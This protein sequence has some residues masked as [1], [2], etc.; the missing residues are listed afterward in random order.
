MSAQSMQALAGA[1]EVRLAGAA[2]RREL[3]K[4]PRREGLV[5]C[6]EWLETGGNGAEGVRLRKLLTAIHRMGDWGA[7]DLLNTAATHPASQVRYVRELTERQRHTL[8]GVLRRKAA[9]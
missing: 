9:A 2:A 1:N 5:R 7:T 4:L 3:G 8:A 6:A